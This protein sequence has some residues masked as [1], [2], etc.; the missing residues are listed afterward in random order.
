[1]L[2]DEFAAKLRL[3][4]FYKLAFLDDVRTFVLSTDS[5]SDLKNLQRLLAEESSEGEVAAA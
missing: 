5:D 1:M 4:K 2:D 3:G